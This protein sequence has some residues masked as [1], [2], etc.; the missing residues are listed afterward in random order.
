MSQDYKI[1][2]AET[3]KINLSIQ[4]DDGTN[5]RLAYSSG[6]NK[7]TEMWFNGTVSKD[8]TSFPIRFKHDKETTQD[9]NRGSEQQTGIFGITAYI[10][11]DN[12]ETSTSTVNSTLEMAEG[13]WNYV[14]RASE[15]KNPKGIDSVFV[16]SSG[17]IEVSKLQDDL[18]TN[19]A[20]FEFEEAE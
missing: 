18:G 7:V 9:I 17:T 11:A 15:A 6:S 5:R 19:P 13:T 14:I 1:R 16:A 10:P 8:T 12:N 4:Q 20:N 2:Q 3:F